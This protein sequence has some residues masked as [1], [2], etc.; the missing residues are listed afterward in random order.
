M[1]NEYH[2]QIL[3]TEYSHT[4]VDYYDMCSTYMV[5]ILVLFTCN[6]KNMNCMA[7]IILC[8][9]YFNISDYVSKSQYVS[10]NSYVN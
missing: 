8:H 6:I 3:T 4:E 2:N 1:L 5:F 9:Q 10:K 7:N